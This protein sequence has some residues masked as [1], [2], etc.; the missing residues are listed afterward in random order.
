[1]SSVSPVDRLAKAPIAPPEYKAAK[2]QV[3]NGREPTDFRSRPTLNS[4]SHHA[5]D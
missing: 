4:A 5:K 1:M 3:A 2:E